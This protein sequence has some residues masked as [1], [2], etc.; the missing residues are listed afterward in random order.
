MVF[1]RFIN[2]R[3]FLSLFNIIK[4]VGFRARQSKRGRTIFCSTQS[5]GRVCS[6]VRI[7]HH[8]EVQCPRR[9]G[10]GS[11]KPIMN[12]N[13]PIHFPGSIFDISG[14]F[15]LLLSSHDHRLVCGHLWTLDVVLPSGPDDEY[16]KPLDG[17]PLVGVGS[18]QDL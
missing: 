3:R 11:D 4:V 18:G 15:V 16:P 9:S 8:P 7:T 17:S 5:V 14:V 2:F 6:F 12:L 1:Q 10:Q 13:N